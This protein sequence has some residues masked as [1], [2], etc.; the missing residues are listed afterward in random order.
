MSNKSVFFRKIISHSAKD[1]RKFA[2][3]LARELVKKYAGKTIVIGL[4]GDLGSAKTTFTQGF[5][6]ALGAKGAI[7]SPTFVIAREYDLENARYY[8]AYHAD[9][10][11]LN[12]T[13]AE[14]KLLRFPKLFKEK[15]SIILIEWAE[16]A[17][18]FLPKN[19]I[20]IKFSHKD[21][22]KRVIEV[23]PHRFTA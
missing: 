16:K 6:R 14:F 22:N 7:I 17:K 13:G 12:V 21:K 10:Y 23:E 9:L 2:A 18:K 8:R 1:T 20:W 3:D 11:R 15:N 5:L 19:T 4:S